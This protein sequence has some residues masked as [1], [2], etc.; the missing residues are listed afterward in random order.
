MIN[1]VWKTFL[2]HSPKINYFLKELL[3]TLDSFIFYIVIFLG[4]NF[5]WSPRG[6]SIYLHVIKF[7]RGWSLTVPTQRCQNVAGIAPSELL[8]PPFKVFN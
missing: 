1:L 4:L 3:K 5:D 2:L 8:L 6:H 7:V